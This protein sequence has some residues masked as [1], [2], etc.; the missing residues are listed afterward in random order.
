VE[1]GGS[2]AQ[3]AEEIINRLGLA[4]TGDARTTR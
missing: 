1:I 3:L 2:A 4:A